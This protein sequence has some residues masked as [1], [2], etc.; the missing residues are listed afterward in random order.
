MGKNGNLFPSLSCELMGS[1]AES[2]SL[3]SSCIYLI[4]RWLH[5]M[6]E[7]DEKKIVY[8]YFKQ[9]SQDDMITK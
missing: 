3:L 1:K 4:T 7:H 6:T 9:R 2:E 5:V 8:V